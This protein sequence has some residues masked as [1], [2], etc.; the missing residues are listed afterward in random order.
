MTRAQSWPHPIA[1]GAVTALGYDI[2]GA[3]VVKDW[4]K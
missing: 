1:I 2:D 4:R 3:A